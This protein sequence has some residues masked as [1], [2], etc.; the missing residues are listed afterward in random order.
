MGVR[1]E[2]SLSA[3]FSP[4]EELILPPNSGAVA[5][6]FLRVALPGNHETG[7]QPLVTL[8]TLAKIC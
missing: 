3:P 6:V 1:H 4:I 7:G 8:K 5:L 2:P